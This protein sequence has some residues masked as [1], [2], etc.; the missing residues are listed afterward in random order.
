MIHLIIPK[1]ALLNLFSYHFNLNI[2]FTI[3]VFDLI[4]EI[5]LKTCYS[6]SKK[7]PVGLI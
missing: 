7:T 6:I 2:F 4:W 3:A 1:I 5:V